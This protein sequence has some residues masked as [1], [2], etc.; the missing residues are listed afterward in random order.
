LSLSLPVLAAS[1]LLL[2]LVCGALPLALS[3]SDRKHHSLLAAATG[4]FLGAVF[5]EL[6]PSIGSHEAHEHAAVEAPASAV[7]VDGHGHGHGHDH[8]SDAIWIAVLLGLLAVYLVESLLLRSRD[9]D[10]HHR[11]RAVAWAALL[12]LS[13]QAA[14]S[15]L[16]LAADG[17]AGGTSFAA[18]LH[19]GAEAFALGTVFALAR[20]RPAKARLAL[21]VF[22]LL[23]P[24][25]I[26]AG[27]LLGL[28]SGH[29]PHFVAWLAG[30]AAGIFLFVSLCELLPEVFHHREDALVKIA[31]LALGIAAIA[32]QMPD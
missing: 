15:G 8:G 29:L 6:L 1:L 22:A 21:V 13:I 28:G 32:V 11:H 3:W 5:L 18:L 12:G 16:A 24:L 9:R 19:K 26:L 14:I 23:G 30:F 4:I 20:I 17:L 31:L 7:P 25:G 27:K 2:A 10:D